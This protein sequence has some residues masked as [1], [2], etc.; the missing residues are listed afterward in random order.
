MISVTSVVKNGRVFR[1]PIRKPLML[2]STAPTASVAGITRP[3]GHSSTSRKN[4][5]EKLHS[6]KIAPTLRSMPPEIRQNPIASA[7]KP[8][9]ANSRSSDSMFWVDA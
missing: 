7:T 2:P 8:N 4:S 5:A 1:Y 3:T 6:A 9:S